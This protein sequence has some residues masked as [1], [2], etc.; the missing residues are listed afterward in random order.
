[1]ANRRHAPCYLH[2][3]AKRC[4]ARQRDPDFGSAPSAPV[5]PRMHV[6]AP[7]ARYAILEPARRTRPSGGRAHRH[8]SRRV[9]AIDRADR[10]GW[11]PSARHAA[12]RR[13]RHLRRAHRAH[14]PEVHGPRGSHCRT[15][16]RT[17]GVAANGMAPTGAQPGLPE[18][19][20][21]QDRRRRPLTCAFSQVCHTRNSDAHSI[22]HPSG[23]HRR[24][25]FPLEYT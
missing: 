19:R 14:R 20:T 9:D 16:P 8:A 7:Q 11:P 6:S 23:L 2:D 15:R 4:A 13:S 1:M 3:T 18:R 24:S 21:P 22:T 12:Q 17:C 25:G 5:S 10:K